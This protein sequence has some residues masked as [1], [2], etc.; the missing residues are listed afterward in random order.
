M[1]RVTWRIGRRAGLGMSRRA[2]NDGL[3]VAKKLTELP[4]LAGKAAAGE[5]SVEQAK[6]VVA[7]AETGH[8]RGVG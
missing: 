7:L 8:R 4:N 3:E 5:L 2:A 6:P 1:G